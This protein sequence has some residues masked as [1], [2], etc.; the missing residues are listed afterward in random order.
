M[1]GAVSTFWKMNC[2]SKAAK[3]GLHENRNSQELLISTASVIKFNGKVK[4]MLLY[5]K[6]ISR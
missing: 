6:D 5:S 1:T 2:W 3:K 4:N